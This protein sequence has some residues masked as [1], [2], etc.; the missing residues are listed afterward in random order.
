MSYED[1]QRERLRLKSQH[2]CVS[3][4]ISS[5][6][7]QKSSSFTAQVGEMEG[8][9]FNVGEVIAEILT[10]RKSLALATEQTRT[11]LRLIAN[12]KKKNVLNKLKYTLTTIKGFYETEQLIR[13]KIE[14]GCFPVA[15]Q[16][17]I[18]TQIQAANY[19]QFTPVK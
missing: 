16:M 2:T 4:K 15:I 7:V 11:C 17:L 5:L 14:E 12:E 1:I 18:E 19:K 3:K 10:I 9:R 13:Q 8:I 6:I